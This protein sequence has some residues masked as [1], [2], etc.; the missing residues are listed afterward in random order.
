MTL[1]SPLSLCNIFKQL[2]WVFEFSKIAS[3][4]QKCEAGKVAWSD[5]AKRVTPTSPGNRE[6]H[7]GSEPGFWSNLKASEG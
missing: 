5:V 1:I 4:L 2:H 7:Q 3:K 6:D